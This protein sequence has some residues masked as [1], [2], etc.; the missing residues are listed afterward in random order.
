LLQL[1]LAAA[2]GVGAEA[3]NAGEQG[4]AATTLLLGQEA[5]DKPASPLVGNREQVVEGPVML[6]GGAVRLLPA[7]PAVTAVKR[8]WLTGLV[9][10]PLPPLCDPRGWYKVLYAAIRQ[11]IF[12]RRLT[13][14]R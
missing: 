13:L 8:R 11:L 2:D 6:G 9:H 4:D 10:S 3:R 5:N 12:E 7:D 1:A 14:L